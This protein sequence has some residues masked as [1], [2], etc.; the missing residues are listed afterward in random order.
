MG[1]RPSGEGVL[2]NSVELCEVVRLCTFNRAGKLKG[3]APVY[4]VSKTS[5]LSER[6]LPKVR[7]GKRK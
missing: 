5:L 3:K 4:D 1:R 2:L 6:K 7:K